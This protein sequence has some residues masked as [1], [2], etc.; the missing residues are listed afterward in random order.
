MD[1]RA[2]LRNNL[3]RV[4]CS[5]GAAVLS[6]PIL[7]FLTFRKPRDKRVIF[8]LLKDPQP[9]LYK[10]G[11]FLVPIGR[12][13]RALSARC[14]HLGCTLNYDPVSLKFRC[15]CHGSQFDISGKRIAGPAKRDLQV[16]PIDKKG[17]GELVVTLKL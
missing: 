1:R 13:H 4:L 16:L 11:V 15:P 14:T 12:S 9:I 8:H 17:K 6:Y 2:F 7:A 3:F 10:E 5:I